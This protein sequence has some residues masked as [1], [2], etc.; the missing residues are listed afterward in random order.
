[1]SYHIA[2]ISHSTLSRC[3]GYAQQ[4]HLTC[5]QKSNALLAAMSERANQRSEVASTQ[6]AGMGDVSRHGQWRGK[7]GF[8][9]D[10]PQ[11]NLTLWI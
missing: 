7:D 2:I 10:T 9:D 6:E 5:L 8:F 1:M 3:A 4:G 11:L